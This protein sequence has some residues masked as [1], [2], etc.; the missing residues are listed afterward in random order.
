MGGRPLQHELATAFMFLGCRTLADSRPKAAG[1]GAWQYFK[2]YSP[3]P[4]LVCNDS[5]HHTDG[6]LNFVRG[7]PNT[8]LTSTLFC[9]LAFHWFILW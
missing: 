5:A 2:P 7:H 1:E 3:G 4:G 8:R 6:R 9:C